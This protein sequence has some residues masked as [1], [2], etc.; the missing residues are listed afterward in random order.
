LEI[1]IGML[2]ASRCQP[3]QQPR[4]RIEDRAS[5]CVVAHV[6]KHRRK[7]CATLDESRN[8]IRAPKESASRIGADRQYF[9]CG[10]AAEPQTECGGQ[11]A[12]HTRGWK[13]PVVQQPA[14]ESAAHYMTHGD[15]ARQWREVY[16]VHWRASLKHQRVR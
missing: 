9:R 4:D 13:E 11:L 14:D 12:G 8:H 3:R 6:A 2:R 7:I 1:E 10:N 15:A 5:L 16:R